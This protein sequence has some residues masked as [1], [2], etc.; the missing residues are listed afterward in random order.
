MGDH[1]RKP[2]NLTFNLLPGRLFQGIYIVW[3]LEIVVY[4]ERH[5]E[6]ARS[7]TRRFFAALAF[8]AVF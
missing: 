7:L 6:R 5:V 1:Y 3:D 4:R 2:V 8:R